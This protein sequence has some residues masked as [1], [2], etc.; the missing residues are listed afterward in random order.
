MVRLDWLFR[1]SLYLCLFVSTASLAFAVFGQLADTIV[2]Y[3]PMLILIVVAYRLND[4]WTLSVRASNILAVLIMIAWPAWLFIS[5]KGNRVRTDELEVELVR[6]ALPFG[7]PLLSTL[8]LA[9]LFR[10]KTV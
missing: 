5:L 3:I 8:L 1:F 6:L 10:P 7:A 9:K 2:F 4:R